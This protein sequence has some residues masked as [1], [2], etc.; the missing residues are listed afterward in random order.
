[1]YMNTSWVHS[2]KRHRLHES[3]VLSAKCDIVTRVEHGCCERKLPI[4]TGV[5]RVL[6]WILRI[7]DAGVLTFLLIYRRGKGCNYLKYYS[8]AALVEVFIN[9]HIVNNTL[10]MKCFILNVCLEI[11]SM[12]KIKTGVYRV[13]KIKFAPLCK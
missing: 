2:I 8:N 12:R 7:A 11:L 10:T 3:Q 9:S 4:S 6:I 5:P 13:I 1:M